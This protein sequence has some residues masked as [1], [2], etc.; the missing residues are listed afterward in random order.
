ME[1]MPK[2]M[3]KAELCGTCIHYRQHYIL[4]EDGRFRPLWYGH[5]HRPKS[6][7]PLPNE[8]CPRFEPY[9]KEPVSPG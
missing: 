2:P 1:R 6:R 3:V 5:C 8:T 9:E 7:H 4:V